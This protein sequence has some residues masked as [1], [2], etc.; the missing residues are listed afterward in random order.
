MTMLTIEVRNAEQAA[1]GMAEVEIFCDSKGLALLVKQLDFL[2][3]GSSHVH[4]MTPAWAGN[5]LEEK[6]FSHDA[7]LV[8]HL[9]I[10]MIPPSAGSNSVDTP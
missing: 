3:A 6:T 7:H 10:N 9:R 8:H 1:S 5:E 4:L 2:R